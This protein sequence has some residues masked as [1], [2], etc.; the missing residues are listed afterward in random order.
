MSYNYIKDSWSLNELISHCVQEE[1]RLKHEK[2][3]SAHLA[4]TFKDKNDKKRKKDKD[5]AD[6]APQKKQQK[7]QTEDGC[8]FCRAANHRK[9]H[10]ANYHT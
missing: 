5:A 6:V 1:E 8:Y 4:T 7:E 10:C 9:K 2:A 3:E